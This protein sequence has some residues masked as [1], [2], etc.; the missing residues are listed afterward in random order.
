MD[1]RFDHRSTNR[2]SPAGELIR[3]VQGSRRTGQRHETIQNVPGRSA[4]S[5]R[6]IYSLP[7][8][9]MAN[10]K[11]SAAAPSAVKPAKVFRRRGIAVSVFANIFC[12]H[13]Q[14]N[15]AICCEI[16]AVWVWSKNSGQSSVAR[17]RY[18]HAETEQSFEGDNL[19]AFSTKYVTS[20]F[21]NGQ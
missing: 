5:I 4:R 18:N 3:D 1:V 9:C 21:S 11:E 14:H 13:R 10:A 16:I 7:P 2:G 20:L 17:L 8:F 12:R 15:A 6:R 19:Q